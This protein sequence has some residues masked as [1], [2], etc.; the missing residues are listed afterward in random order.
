M[1]SRVRCDD[2]DRG[3]DVLSVADNLKRTLSPARAN[4]DQLL[5]SGRG[6]EQRGAVRADAERERH[7]EAGLE[8]VETGEGR[9]VLDTDDMP[10]LAEGV[11]VG[12]VVRQV[13]V[14]ALVLGRSELDGGVVRERGPQADAGQ[15]RG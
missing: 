12:V 10:A 13:V 7:E 6:D 5:T 15:A 8:A 9:L 4:H 2:A 3:R 14:A 1:S 11:D